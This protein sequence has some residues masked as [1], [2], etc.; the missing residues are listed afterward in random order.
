M[1]TYQY[2][3]LYTYSHIIHYIVGPRASEVSLPP[4]TPLAQMFQPVP[5]TKAFSTGS[6]TVLGFRSGHPSLV[7]RSLGLFQVMSVNHL[8]V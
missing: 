8:G 1:K 5:P 6:H 2:I 7:K 3:T 4:N